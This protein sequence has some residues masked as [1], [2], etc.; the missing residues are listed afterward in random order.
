MKPSKIVVW[1]SWLIA[2][3]ALVAAAIGL[4]YQD[5]GTA[6]SFTTLRGQTVQIYGQGLYRY[7]IPITAVGYRAADAVT[8]VLAIPLLVISSLLYRHGSL[9]GGLGLS[10]ALAYFLY[11]YGSMAVGAAYNSLFL[12]YVALFSASLFGLVLSLTSFDVQGLPAHFTGGLPRRGIGMFLVVSGAILLLVW[13]VLSIVPALFQGTAPPE[14][15]SYTT[16]ITGVV[17]IGIVAPALIVAG[18]LLLRRASTGYL[19]AAMM[20]VFT[21]ALGPNLTV[22]GIAQLLT[23]VISIGQFIGMTVPF[24][25]LMLIAIWLTIVLFRNFAEAMTPQEARTRVAHA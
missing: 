23:G 20:L 8:L 25:I 10:G 4:F 3:L 1:L 2:A 24:M 12:V 15:A 17:D 13:L 18:V 6:F 19:L 5:G 22:A 14:V 7:D 9:K 21:V 16:F 11:N